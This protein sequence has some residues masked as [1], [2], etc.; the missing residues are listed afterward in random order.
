MISLKKSILIAGV[1]ALVLG[2]CGDDRSHPKGVDENGNPIVYS[3]PTAIIDINATTHDF[4]NGEYTLD[5]RNLSNPFIFDGSRSHDNDEDNQSI[6]QYAWSV[7]H[8]FSNACVDI[9]KTG[10]RAVFKFINID[11][12]TTCLNEARDN[13]EINVTLT[14]TDNENKT[15]TATRNIKTN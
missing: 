5:R 4:I 7:N 2:G 9:N 8:S 10:N 6:S 3:N 12:N 14:V 1:V 11:T 13:G 15:A